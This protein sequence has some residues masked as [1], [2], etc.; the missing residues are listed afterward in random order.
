[1]LR[2]SAK[3]R[4]DEQHR[5]RIGSGPADGAGGGAPPAPEPSDHLAA[6]QSRRVDAGADRAV[7]P[8]DD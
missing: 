5:E 4:A 6:A 2:A 8:R 1:M 3:E 7:G